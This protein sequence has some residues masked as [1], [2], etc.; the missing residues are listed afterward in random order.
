VRI[1]Q[2]ES[3]IALRGTRSRPVRATAGKDLPLRVRNRTAE[4]G[5]PSPYLV[6]I[7]NVANL[8]ERVGTGE[9]IDRSGLCGHFGGESNADN[10]ASR[11]RSAAQ[12]SGAIF[13]WQPS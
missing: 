4:S 1:K 13:A 12:L 6:E 2:G 7:A 5:E 10:R 11:L 9:R 3:G 8:G